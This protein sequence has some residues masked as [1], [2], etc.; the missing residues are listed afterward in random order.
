MAL[1]KANGKLRARRLDMERIDSA[2]AFFSPH[3][4]NAL[5]SPVGS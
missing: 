2:P 1:G 5:F 3:F 4:G